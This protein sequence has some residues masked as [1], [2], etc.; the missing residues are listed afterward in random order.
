MQSKT[1]LL[2]RHGKSDWNTAFGSD[3]QRPLAP[4]GEKAARLIGDWLHRVDLRPDRVLSSDA[5]RALTTAQLAA[6]A[7][8]WNCPIDLHPEFYSG[9]SADL[10]RAL[11]HLDDSVTTVLLAGH[12]PT[13]SQTAA[14]LSGGGT[15]RFPTAA[16]ACLVASGPWTKVAPGRCELNWF[17]TPKLLAKARDPRGGATESR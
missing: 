1:I 14:L 5:V 7:G 11:N 17:V 4:R 8:D 9:S 15:F 13:W 2:L 16:L 6:E 10:V 3:H 12:Q